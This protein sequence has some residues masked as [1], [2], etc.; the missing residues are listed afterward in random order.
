[1]HL[2]RF[3]YPLTL[4][5]LAPVA[6]AGNTADINI[7]ATIIKNTCQ[8]DSSTTSVN[9]G[10]G[11]VDVSTAFTGGGWSHASRTGTIVLRDCDSS[12]VSTLMVTTAQTSDSGN[13]NNWLKNSG[14][15]TGV[16][17]QLKSNRAV[18]V[19]AAQSGMRLGD[20]ATVSYNSAARTA[21][22]GVEA[23]LQQ[24]TVGTA[25]RPG[26]VVAKSTFTF[27]YQ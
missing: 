2:S 27:T 10:F 8:V 25:P 1:M 12:D 13:I 9:L 26:S 17:V 20:F 22:F 15:A 18:Y 19:Q 14:S 24:T 23:W 6:L 16:A 7:S 3:A 21:S 4:A 5:V 11:N